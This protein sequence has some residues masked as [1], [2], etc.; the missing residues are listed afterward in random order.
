MQKPLLFV[1]LFVLFSFSFSCVRLFELVWLIRSLSID[2]I[3]SYLHTT[4]YLSILIA[5]DA[6][7][8]PFQFTQYTQI[9]RMQMVCNVDCLP[10]QSNMTIDQLYPFSS[11]FQCGEKSYRNRQTNRDDLF[12]GLSKMPLKTIKAIEKHGRKC[13][14]LQ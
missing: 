3:W 11:S 10:H 9:K 14:D 5:L 8:Y 7:A 6:A 1:R 2:F 12:F 13:A 4:L